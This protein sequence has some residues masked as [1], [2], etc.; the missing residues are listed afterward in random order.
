MQF[1]IG[2]PRPTPAPLSAVLDAEGPRVSEATTVIS[3]LPNPRH[4][5]QFN[6]SVELQS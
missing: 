2:L 1:G 5:L 6:V 4:P 3:Q